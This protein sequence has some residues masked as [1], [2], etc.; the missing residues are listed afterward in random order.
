MGFRALP[1]PFDGITYRS[2]LEARWAVFFKKLD[3]KAEYEPQG[4]DTDGEWYLPD[5][6]IFGATGIT[7]AEIKPTWDA[8]PEGIERFRRFAAARPQPSRAVLLVGPP[9]ADQGYLVIGGDEA[10]EDP[11][12]G[13]WEA[14]DF[15]WRPCQGGY[16]FDLAYPGHFKARF[17][18]DA[19]ED[20][21]GG[22]GEERI[23]D[24][25]AKARSEKFSPKRHQGSDD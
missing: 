1:T 18:K 20:K 12:N 21:F 3:L 19:C 14:D 9:R 24:A 23:E 8:D 6:A 4:W 7:W 5:F 11:A 2:R 13:P 17:A 15:T 25:A 10:A 16:H 22:R